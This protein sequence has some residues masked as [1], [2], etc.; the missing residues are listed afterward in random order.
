MELAFQVLENRYPMAP[1]CRGEDFRLRRSGIGGYGSVW[2][3]TA[4][5]FSR[6]LTKSVRT[7]FRGEEEK[8]EVHLDWAFICRV[9]AEK[10]GGNLQIKNREGGGAKITVNF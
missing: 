2:K 1:I 7:L 9:I 4:R 3:T 10:H 5:G 6:S 8:S